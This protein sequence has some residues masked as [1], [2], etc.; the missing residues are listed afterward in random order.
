MVQRDVNDNNP[1]FGSFNI[2]EEV[3]RFLK[4][5]PW[6]VVWL[7][8]AIVAAFFYLRYTTPIYKATAS[9]IIN[10]EKGGNSGSEMADLGL[11]TGLKTSSIEKEIA[12]LRSRRLMKKVVEAL[13]LNVTYFKE[14][15]VHDIEI[16]KDAPFSLKILRMDEGNIAASGGGVFKVSFSTGGKLQIT[17]VGTEES[18][19]ASPGSPVDL[20]FAD[21]VFV[22]KKEMGSFSD[23]TV[24]FFRIEN[25]AASYRGKLRLLQSDKNSNVIEVIMEDPVLEKAK[26]V[27]DQLIFEFNRDAIDD[28]NLIAGNTANFINE[29][30]EIINDE[31]EQVETGKE[32]FKENNR[33]TDIQ[34]ES[35][36]YMQNAS[37]YNKRREEVGTQMELTNAMLDYLATSSNSELLPAN[38]GIEESGLNQQI[39]E[40]NS[41]VLERN[42]I[43]GGSTEKNP[44]VIRLNS[45]IDQIKANILQSLQRL[46]YNLQVS[47]D[48]LNRHSSSIG[49]RILA[50]PSQERQFRGIE[51]QQSIKEA[52]YLFLLQKREENSLALAVTAPKAKI[53]DAAFG[54][55]GVVSPNSR[56]IILG[57]V[58]LGLFIP[59]SIVYAKGL[60]DNKIRRR[61]D[62]ENI[63]KDL[64]FAGDLPKMKKKRDC[65]IKKNDRSVLAESFRILVANL[66]YLLIDS[67]KKKG[68]VNILVTST[69]KG[70][71]KTFTSVNLG[72]TLANTGKRV[73]ILGADL[74][75]PKLLPFMQEKE[76]VLGIS[77]YL[78]NNSLCLNKLI[79]K[80][81]L[82]PELDILV[83]GTK[84]P[85]PTELIGH[86]KVDKMLYELGGSY[87]YI[88]LDTAPAM[89]VADTFLITKFADLT[90]YVVKAGCTEKK[91]LDFVVDSKKAGAFKNLYFVLNNVDHINL[92][93][94]SKY[95]YGYG[96][97]KKSFWHLGKARINS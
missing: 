15:K 78:V 33:L 31:L 86:E 28:K 55:G 12:I 57:S 42:R 39:G 66:Q 16:Y 64:L 41:L 85:N 65:V 76:N 11:I 71:G 24:Q 7:V 54:S 96:N 40:Y 38:L 67:T 95:G 81:N 20:G 82:H 45:R 51:R 43:L 91:L 92:G 32:E 90:L 23:Y 56:S 19:L 68:A 25:V 10:E 5:W 53:V 48:D 50:V 77:D 1:S 59:F 26:D 88:I 80:S 18:F 62:I 61:R 8:I 37:E 30:L 89:L 87:D 69:V 29:R 46:R 34:A 75:S 44:V 9:I 36:M 21:V 17:N 49:S 84:P 63:G 14:G 35:K 73:L 93:Y 27:I 60:L 97:V 47:L 3:D 22:P 58:I 52:L 6:F 13:S 83:S 70:E 74:R 4:Y 2:R 94:G 79:G 72:V